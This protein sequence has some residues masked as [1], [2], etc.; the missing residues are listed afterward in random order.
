MTRQLHAVP[1]GKGTHTPCCEV[2]EIKKYHKRKLPLHTPCC[3]VTSCDTYRSG[4]LN[5][6]LFCCRRLAFFT[7]KCKWTQK[8]FMIYINA[9]ESRGNPFSSCGGSREHSLLFKWKNLHS[10]GTWWPSQIPVLQKYVPPVT[11]GVTL[12]CHI[13]K[14]THCHLGLVMLCTE[15]VSY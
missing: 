2:T 9:T 1:D 7:G 12:R 5:W 6:S 14:H 4:I 8:G 10:A 3:E 15:S 11:I 13:C